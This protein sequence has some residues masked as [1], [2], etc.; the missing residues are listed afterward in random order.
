MPAPAR[1]FAAQEISDGPPVPVK[2]ICKFPRT[3]IRSSASRG[4][5]MMDRRRR[6][7]AIAII[8]TA[9]LSTEAAPADG[10]MRVVLQQASRK[11][12]RQGRADAGPPVNGTPRQA[13]SGAA[14][15][16]VDPPPLGAPVGSGWKCRCMRVALH[17][18]PSPPCA[19]CKLN[20]PVAL[21]RVLIVADFRRWHFDDR[22]RWTSTPCYSR[23]LSSV[24]GRS[25]TRFPVA[26]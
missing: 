17:G 19:I 5:W 23:N 8:G 7:T 9:S 13:F 22:Q 11:R 6:C 20:N 3:V 16:I 10:G 2:K 1:T 14:V 15:G 12:A 25:R 21:D 26:W 24:I 4:C 18:L